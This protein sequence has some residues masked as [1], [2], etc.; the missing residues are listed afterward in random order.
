MKRTYIVLFAVFLSSCGTPA[1]PAA[2]VTSPSIRTPSM[3]Q[4]PPV[5]VTPVCI[6]SEPTQ[7]D[8]D[9]VLSYTDDVFDL[10]VW[11]Q[12]YEVGDQG[13]SVTW[14]NIPQS[15][16]VFLEAIIFPCGYEEPD[17][18]HYL[19][20]AHWDALF[21]NYDSYEMVDECRS[22]TGLRLYQFEA[23]SQ[24]FDYSISYWSENDT[25]ERIITTMITFPFGSE[26][27]LDDYAAQLFPELTHCS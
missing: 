26:A 17:L 15:A 3:T 21:A 8:V 4:L 2:A 14:Q 7:D 24:G 16:V 18:N 25:A 1:A 6:S 12:S 19:N 5:T 11:E 23:V 9:A 20:D 13:V 27:T 22:D 10:A